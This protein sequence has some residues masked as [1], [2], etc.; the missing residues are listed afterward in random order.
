MCC[1][2]RHFFV[3]RFETPVL[4]LTPKTEKYCDPHLVPLLL[5]DLSLSVNLIMNSNHLTTINRKYFIG[6]SVFELF[7]NVFTKNIIN[8]LKETQQVTTKYNADIQFKIFLILLYN[9]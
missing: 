6:Q 3:L 9:L 1:C 4:A 8:I 5:P 7:S 2:C